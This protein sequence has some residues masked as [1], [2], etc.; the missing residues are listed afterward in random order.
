MTDTTTLDDTPDAEELPE[1]VESESLGSGG[2]A[3]DTPLKTRV[4]LPLLVPIFSILIAV[5]FGVRRFSFAEP[6]AAGILAVGEIEI[7]PVPGGE[8][9]VCVGVGVAA[10]D[11]FVEGGLRGKEAGEGGAGKLAGI[12]RVIGFELGVANFGAGEGVGEKQEQ[13]DVSRSHIFNT[14]ID[15]AAFEVI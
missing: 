12:P 1:L 2:T 4:L 8:G 3:E 10:G 9:F 14:E 6:A 15:L 5:P 7:P 11:A 13:E